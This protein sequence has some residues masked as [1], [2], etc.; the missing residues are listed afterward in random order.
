MRPEALGGDTK[1]ERKGRGRKLDGITVQ[2]Q[3]RH[4]LE[5]FKKWE[6]RRRSV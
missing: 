1:M 5:L 3:G 2:K 4:E 6:R